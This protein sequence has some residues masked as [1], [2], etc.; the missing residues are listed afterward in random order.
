MVAV[1]VAVAAGGAS[2]G[3]ASVP[4]LRIKNGHELH[5][6]LARSREAATGIRPDSRSEKQSWTL[7]LTPEL[8]GASAELEDV[9]PG[10]P[11]SRWSVPVLAERVVLDAA[12]FLPSHVYRV[13]V[14]RERQL[15]GSGLVYLYPPPAERVSRVRFDEQTDAKAGAFSPAVLPKGGL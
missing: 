1:A 15:L 13:E 10:V 5:V 7:Q 4:R 2:A 9:T 3:E 14:R 11:G 8:A 12:R 6:A